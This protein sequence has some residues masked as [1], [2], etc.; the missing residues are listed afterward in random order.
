[1]DQNMKEKFTRTSETENCAEHCPSDSF[2][3]KWHLEIEINITSINTDDMK[4]SAMKLTVLSTVQIDIFL[5][6]K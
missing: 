1:M 5:L 4:I 3:S 6:Q 2:V